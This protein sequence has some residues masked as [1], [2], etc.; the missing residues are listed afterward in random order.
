MRLVAPE[1][2]KQPQRGTKDTTEEVV[3]PL[4]SETFLCFLCLFVAKTFTDKGRGSSARCSRELNQARR[5]SKE[6][7]N[8]ARLHRASCLFSRSYRSQNSP[9]ARLQP[10]SP[11]RAA[12]NSDTAAR[13]PIRTVQLH[14]PAPASLPHVRQ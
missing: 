6:S 10:E 8:R 2:T 5:P 12:A 4:P 7:R 1:R 11:A 13:F 9:P 14:H 3:N